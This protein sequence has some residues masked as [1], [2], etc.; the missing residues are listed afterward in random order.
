LQVMSLGDP[1]VQAPVPVQTVA[2]NC[3]VWFCERQLFSAYT[4]TFV[5]DPVLG[6]L[7]HVCTELDPPNRTL[8]T[9]GWTKTGTGLLVAPP[10]LAVR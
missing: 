4:G 2:A 8:V 7:G 6:L 3:A 10:P 1:E 9:G 5:G